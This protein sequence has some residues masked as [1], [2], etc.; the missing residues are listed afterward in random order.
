MTYIVDFKDNT[1]KEAILAYFQANNITVLQE[2]DSLGSVYSVQSAS[3]PPG[4]D[5]VER[6]S[7]DTDLEIV[8]MLTYKTFPITEDDEHWWKIA[9]VNIKDFEVSTVQHPLNQGK[10]NVYILDSGIKA[11]HQEFIGQDITNLYSY[12]GTF[13][14]T[15]GHGTAIAS[16]I[17]GVNCSLATAKIKVVKIFGDTPTYQSHMLAALDAILKDNAV[18]GQPG[19]ANLSW[20]IPK[21]TYIEAKLQSLIDNDILVVCSAGNNGVP[22]VD[23]TPASMMD[24]ITVGS[25][26]K[27]FEPSDFSNYTSPNAITNTNMAVNYGEIDIWAPGEYIYVASL[28]GSYSY[29]AGTSMAA[30]IETMSLAYQLGDRYSAEG[31]T[32]EHFG[33][34]NYKN[35]FA[36]NECSKMGLLT[37]TGNYLSSVNRATSIHSQFSNSNNYQTRFFPF[38]RFKIKH[39]TDFSHP[40]Y[41]PR[42]SVTREYVNELPTGVYFENGWM[43][44]KLSLT[45][46]ETHRYMEIE[47]IH[48]DDSNELSAT[49]TVQIFLYRE[50]IDYSQDPTVDPQLD[51]TLNP[52][53]DPF[54]NAWATP[55]YAYQ[56]YCADQCD[57]SPA[58]FCLDL[59]YYC[60]G[61]KTNNCECASAC[62]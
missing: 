17:T 50:G 19:I 38:M 60:F 23:V 35:Y 34:T 33:F 7:T 52:L 20:N 25:Y 3:L 15:H 39:D 4:T 42:Y 21:N 30:A 61:I 36:S 59:E 58:I 10:V 14:D 53:A 18:D 49:Q 31:I 41:L 2:Y 13:T 1:T 28:D 47:I 22:I 55:N 5:I 9:T 46:S 32:S 11:D 54:C 26:N 62:P 40:V 44:G 51:I 24:A 6:V 27:E 8:P 12:D 56:G 43:K 37:L 48:H 57:P 29:V 16:L 45:E